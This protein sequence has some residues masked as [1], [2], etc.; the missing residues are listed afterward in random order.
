[1]RNVRFASLLVIGVLVFGVAAGGWAAEGKVKVFVLAGQSNMEGHGQLLSLDFLGEH[2]NF[3]HLL[4]RIK[5][6]DGTWTV[7]DD[8]TIAWPGR[9]D[10]ED[11]NGPLTV[12][13]GA[14]PHEIGP[15]LMFGTVVGDAFEEPVLLIKTAWGGKDVF[16]DFRSPSAGEPVGDEVKIL[17]RERADNYTREIGHYYRKMVAGIKDTLANIGEVVPGY[18]GQG[19]ELAGFAWFQ[20]WN[21]C[22]HWHD[23]PGVVEN[24]PRNL[25][26][27]FS[28]LRKD[29]GTVDLPIV[30]G[31]LGV[32]G[33][34]IEK[35]AEDEGDG[36]ANGFVTFR[37]AQRAAAESGLIEN[38][39]F[40]PTAGYWDDRL[41][42][43]REISNRWWG[44]KQEK[45]IKD[46]E[47]NHLPTKEENDE[48]LKRGNH[49]YA[50]YNGSAA[51]YS[52]VGYALAETLLGNDV[53]E[54]SRAPEDEAKAFYDPVFTDIEGWTIAVDP[55]LMEDEHETTRDEA[56]KALANHLQ[57]V[58]YLMPEERLSEMQELG[59]WLDLDHPKLSGMQ[60][61]PSRGWL[62]SNGHDPR[63]EKYVHLARAKEL[64]EPYMW[65]KH[66]YVILHELAHSYHD[67]V[68][69]FEDPAILD[70]YNRSK[71]DGIYEEV[72]LHT[73]KQVRH[74]GLNDQK[75]YFAEATEAYFGV[76]DF[77]PF[78]RAELQEHD[79][80]MY[81]VL[82]GVW[83]PIEGMVPTEDKQ[84]AM[85]PP[86]GW[87]SWNIFEADINEKK[88]K[89]VAD[90]MVESGMRDAG[91]TYLVLDDGWMAKER[92]EEGRL[93]ADPKK[94][95]NGMKAIGDYIH[96]KGL[97]YGIY[98]DRGV[99]TCQQLPGSFGYEEIDMKSFAEW[100]VDY[101]KMDS[102]FAESNGRMSSDD[103]AM[104]RKYIEATGRP[105]ILSIS[106]FGNAAWAWGGKE[107]GQLWRTSYDI[108]PW[109]DSIYY[110]A[111]TTSGENSI[112]PAFNG[113]WQ[114]AG[115]GH[116]N[117][118]D[119][120]QVGN[121]KDMDADEIAVANRAHFSL[122]CM[123]AAPLMAGNDLRSMKK[124]VQEVLTAPEVLAVNQDRRGIQGYKVFDDGD[125]E[126]YNKPLADGTTAVLLL[127]KSEDEADLTVQWEKIGLSGAQPVRD[128]WAREDVGEFEGSF[129]A[130]GLGQNGHRL[131]KVGRPG[132]PL[133]TA[134]RV[135]L[136]EYTVTREGETY[137]T[138]LY[139]IYKAHNTPAYDTNFE[140]ESIQV[141]GQPI[142]KGIGM[143]GRS[144]VMFKITNRADR[145]LASVALD[146]SAKNDSEGRFRVYSEDFFA[147][148]VLWD[149]GE[150][151][152]DMPPKE[153]DLELDGVD[154]L[155]LVFEGDEVLGNWADARVV[156]E[157]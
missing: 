20:G 11:A 69:G 150:M 1:M 47:E 144:A 49:W 157:D 97:K 96:S 102:C 72:L 54:V 93:V 95:P 70:A 22:M 18:D 78:V 73:G 136:E 147:N 132:R 63:L 33:Y 26:A 25:A 3:G 99:M 145:F 88:I 141:G 56:F 23:G 9:D 142:E 138:D 104:Y 123:F 58:K 156:A 52:L 29:L 77:Y 67:Q 35:R 7:R 121:L 149:S 146:P 119:M 134:P 79:P 65:A 114:F 17:E 143:M 125:H 30:I 62:V 14:E 53:P 90:A 106:D 57:R 100:G 131:I 151:K 127:N 40:V 83:G 66:P 16:C 82:Q 139:Y 2:P 112:H 113:L 38:V 68:L 107:S 98:Q 91:Y 120:L 137:L 92:D 76:N 5:D 148:K 75:E 28:D 108:Y 115:P 50:H 111:D 109:M 126:I 103:Y 32:G 51:N 39:T 80:V 6:D 19:Y 8:V 116:W 41:Q 46:T 122:W 31:E 101:I 27:M 43:L 74:Y 60:Y 71:E 117:D 24:Y 85:T 55:K 36:E 133:P 152:K 81:A 21:D 129:T 130:E 153:I 94:F 37:R 110:C 45:G 13:W 124:D 140:G 64:T 4:D 86:M 128:L 34:P 154:T 118:P 135:P 44:E 48:F 10:R 61:H 42:E 84:L 12:G 155:M 15:E 87:N 89:G 59:I 105:M